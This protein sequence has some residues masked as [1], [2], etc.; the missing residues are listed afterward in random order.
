[1]NSTVHPRFWNTAINKMARE[2]V[3]A[4][5]A[6]YNASFE[7]YEALVFEFLGVKRSRKKSA[8]V[9]KLRPRH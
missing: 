4:D 6:A 1:M 7:R 2:K 9:I 3:R 5:F 8:N